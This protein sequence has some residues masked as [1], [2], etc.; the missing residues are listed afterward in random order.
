VRES[1]RGGRWL[2][3]C[4]AGI[5]FWHV[6]TAANAGSI[7]LDTKSI[8][9]LNPK[10]P[11]TIHTLRLTGRIEVGDAD[12]LR[13]MLTRLRAARVGGTDQPLATIEL[14]SSGGDLLEAIKVGYLL[15]E[16]DVATLVHRGD[17]CLSACAIAFL[18]GT[19][20]HLPPQPVAS[21]T[22]EVGGRV[23]FHNFSTDASTIRRETRDD[24]EAGIA[25][26]FGLARAGASALLRYAADMGIEPGFVARMITLPPDVWQFVD[27]NEQFLD[28]RA[29]PVGLEAPLDRP[30][31]QAVNI[32]NHS[33]GW[34]SSA[35]PAQLR[36][37]SA[38]QAKRH[39]LEHVQRNIEA[40]NVKG[41]LVAQLA[42]VIASRD[43]RLIDGV[44]A[45]LRAAG[46]ALP[47][48]HGRDFHIDGYVVGNYQLACHVSL[49][50]GN[51]DRFDVVI[52]GPS[53][54]QRA[55]R[56]PPRACPRL[57]RYGREEM[58]NP[59]R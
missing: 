1:R 50:L 44:Y 34:F 51:P 15:R 5:L 30:E 14:S 18:G 6:A 24:T 16:F 32:C 13:A 57:F 54:L 4:L 48:P 53:A 39:L 58:L 26:S 46:L 12:R 27:S 7:S 47:E 33:T 2:F 28:V 29:C 25:R 21:R 52:I 3:S 9:G 43:D 37:M 31:Q 17:T 56:A 49:S 40:F 55:F 45:D 19:S 22:I 10:T 59:R 38:P 35:T 41:P 11:I 42:A 36:A 20:S 8:P 23:G